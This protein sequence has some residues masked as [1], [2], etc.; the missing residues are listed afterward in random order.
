MV[1]AEQMQLELEKTRSLL[2]DKCSLDHLQE[3]IDL[4][5]LDMSSRTSRKGAPD[6]M[7]N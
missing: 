5:R 4:L 6:P 3:E 2:D 1:G 7:Q